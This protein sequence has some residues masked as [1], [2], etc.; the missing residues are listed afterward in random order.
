MTTNGEAIVD[1]LVNYQ[2]QIQT[3]YDRSEN[4]IQRHAVDKIYGNERDRHTSGM[5]MKQIAETLINKGFG[6][7]SILVEWSFSRCDYWML[8][9]LF[10]QIGLEHVM[11]PKFNSWLL[12]FDWK[13]VV[14][15]SKAALDCRLSVLFLVLQPA[16]VWVVRQAHRAG[17]D[18][19]MLLK[20]T[21]LY[22]DYATKLRQKTQAKIM[23]FFQ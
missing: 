8:F 22:F 19:L 1:T 20:M 16:D 10:E 12:L 18:T 7:E 2:T 17:P 9:R 3:V 4:D 6:P 15:K 13:D 14:Q 21:Q 23:D 11:P 5:T